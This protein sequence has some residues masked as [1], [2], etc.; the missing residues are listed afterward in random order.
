MNIVFYA[1]YRS[2]GF[3]MIQLFSIIH[4][5]SALPPSMSTSLWSRVMYKQ[6]GRRGQLPVSGADAVRA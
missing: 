3:E 2:L 6:V 5:C 4:K 1:S